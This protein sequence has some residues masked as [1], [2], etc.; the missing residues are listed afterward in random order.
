MKNKLGTRKQSDTPVIVNSLF[1]V[2]DEI[3]VETNIERLI[4]V[5]KIKRVTKHP[6]IKGQ[7]IYCLSNGNTLIDF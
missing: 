1:N 3:G 4:E 7:F 6:T 2:G 5:V